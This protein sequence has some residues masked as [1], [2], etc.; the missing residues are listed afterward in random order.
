MFMLHLF[1]ENPPFYNK[2]S[3]LFKKKKKILSECFLIK[4]YKA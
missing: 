4:N 3:N 2:E 1:N